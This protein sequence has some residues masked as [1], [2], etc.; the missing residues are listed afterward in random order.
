MQDQAVF[1]RLM[2]YMLPMT[3]QILMPC[4]FGNE[5]ILA[6]D[7][8]SMSLFHSNW[9]FESKEFKTAMIIFMENAKQPMRITALGI[10]ELSLENFQRIL[11][12]AYS[13]FA[14]LK[15]VNR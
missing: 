8:L 13:L 6:S 7:K 14:V 9:A 12:S 11:N 3:L 5:M 15:N 2:S 10:F 1:G 4:Y